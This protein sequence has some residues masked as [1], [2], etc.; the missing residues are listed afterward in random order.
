MKV[1]KNLILKYNPVVAEMKIPSS[2]RDIKY[3]IQL[4]KDGQITHEPECEAFQFGRECSHIKK[5]KKAW[6]EEWG[7]LWQL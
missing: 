6:E 7:Y 4:H 3:L 1:L 5:A 2:S